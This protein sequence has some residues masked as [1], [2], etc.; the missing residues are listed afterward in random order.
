MNSISNLT[1]H[2]DRGDSW[3]DKNF[4]EHLK[5]WDKTHPDQPTY[6]PIVKHSWEVNG[7]FYQRA[8]P[9]NDGFYELPDS[10]GLLL[11]ENVERPDNLVLLDV[12]GKERMRLS[13]P[14]QL[15]RTP[16]PESAKYPTRFIG[17]T[18]PWDNPKTGEEGKFGVLAWVQ[19]AGDYCFELDY[20]AGKFLWGYFLERG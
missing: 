10:T 13:V 9:R 19:F 3:P 8:N 15:T 7:N 16:T 1:R 5:E 17:L 20:H 12:Y 4:L 2:N 18:T 11:C 14:W 6:G